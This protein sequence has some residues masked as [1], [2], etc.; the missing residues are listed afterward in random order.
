VH[1]ENM[2]W[3]T[4]LIDFFPSTTAMFTGCIVD[5]AGRAPNADKRTTSSLGYMTNFK[6]LINTCIVMIIG[7]E[8][9]G[10]DAATFGSV[11]PWTFC[12]RG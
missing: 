12:L 5:V 11:Y 9:Y 10:L 1:R 3:R 8:V 7:I 6:L 2:S 4:S